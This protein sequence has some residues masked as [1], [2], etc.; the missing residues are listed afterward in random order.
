MR[1][2]IIALV[3]A[4]VVLVVVAVSVHASDQRPAYPTQ[5]QQLTAECLDYSQ[6]CAIN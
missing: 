3:I 5:Q 6:A 2:S 1:R 4:V